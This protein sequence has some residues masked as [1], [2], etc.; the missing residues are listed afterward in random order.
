ML[1]EPR[2]LLAPPYKICQP[3]FGTSGAFHAAYEEWVDILIAFA[4][5]VRDLFLG[6]RSC[7]PCPSLVWPTMGAKYGFLIP[8]SYV[9][10]VPGSADMNTSSIF[11]G[12]SLGVALFSAGKAARQ[13][14]RSWQ[15]AKRVSAYIIMVWGVWISSMIL[16]VLAWGFQRQYIHPR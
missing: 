4:L 9:R 2:A 1:H 12:F 10:E 14:Q 16:G 8:D 15:R 7:I 3:H 13:S 6:S 11:W 5:E